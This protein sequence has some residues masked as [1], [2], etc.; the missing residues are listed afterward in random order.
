MKYP[1][2]K[3]IRSPRRIV[4]QASAQPLPPYTIR[5]NG[6]SRCITSQAQVSFPFPLY[7]CINN[8]IL[9]Q[10]K[11]L[12]YNSSITVAPPQSRHR[13]K[14]GAG[15]VK[16]RRRQGKGTGARDALRL[17]PRY[18]FSY[19]FLLFRSSNML[20]DTIVP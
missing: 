5:T 1:T 7:Y 20:T 12:L 17:E 6:G 18:V 15:R 2:P 8:F 11:L 16:V 9:L 4:S 13:R 3:E 10:T 14:Q 19:F